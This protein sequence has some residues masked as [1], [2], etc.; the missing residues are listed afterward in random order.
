MEFFREQDFLAKYQRHVFVC[1]N[2]REPGSAR[3]SCNADGKSQLQTRFK[4]AVDAARL[5]GT[6]RVN[7]AGCLD[8]CEHGPTVVVYPEAVWYGHVSEA[9]VDEIVASHLVAGRPVKRL[10]LA[11]GCVNTGACEHRLPKT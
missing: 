4:Q 10:L 5:K 2:Q 9:D 7:K 1:T 3:P 6:V 11:E 8:Q